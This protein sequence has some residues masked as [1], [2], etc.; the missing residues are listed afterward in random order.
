VPGLTTDQ[1]GQ[2]RLQG[3]ACDI[4]AVERQPGDMGFFVHLPAVLKG[5]GP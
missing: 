5:V 1:R 2:P 4:G 3:A